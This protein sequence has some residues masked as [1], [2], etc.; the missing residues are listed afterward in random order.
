MGLPNLNNHNLAKVDLGN[1]L[2]LVSSILWSAQVAAGR[3][4]LWVFPRT[5]W[6]FGTLQLD[7]YFANYTYNSTV[8]QVWSSMAKIHYRQGK[9]PR[10]STYVRQTFLQQT[11]YLCCGKA[12]YYIFRT[13]HAAAYWPAWAA[14]IAKCWSHLHLTP[15]PAVRSSAAL[16]ASPDTSIAQTLRNASFVPSGRRSIDCL[17]TRIA[18]GLQPR[19]VALPQLFPVGLTP[20]MH[21]EMSTVVSHPL[22]RPPAVPAQ[23]EHALKF[24]LRMLPKIS[25]DATPFWLQLYGF[26]NY[27]G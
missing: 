12:P 2:T 14:N 21:T 13:A 8:V 7:P 4:V 3:E 10:P 24:Q 17:S 22:Q 1:A 9:V 25:A 5:P 18:S 11:I 6:S 16:P 23:V 20:G 19:D 27:S 26:N 15:L